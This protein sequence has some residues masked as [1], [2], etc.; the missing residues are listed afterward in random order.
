MINKCF[1]MGVDAL[2]SMSTN[3]LKNDL[4][5]LKRCYGQV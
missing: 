5:T 2:G 3:L 1:I 4:C